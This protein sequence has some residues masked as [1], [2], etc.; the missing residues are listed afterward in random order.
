MASMNLR[1]YINGWNPKFEENTRLLGS[2]SGVYRM[3]H[4]EASGYYSK[5][6]TIISIITII[7]VTGTGTGSFSL[8]NVEETAQVKIL[9]GFVLYVTALLSGIKDFLNLTQISEKHKLYSIRFSALY[10]NIQRQLSLYPEERQNGKDYIS[11]VNSE[12]DNLLFSNPDI[13]SKIKNKL[14]DEFG[15]VINRDIYRDLTSNETHIVIDSDDTK[16][17]VPMITITTPNDTEPSELSGTKTLESNAIPIK[18][19]NERSKY[20]I[21]RYMNSR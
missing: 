18:R 15:D 20:E 19:I 16:D 8:V 1:G 4:D 2:K 9:I 6:N 21:E 17:K 10:N 11:W 13:P 12:F 14:L 5:I 7:L 3:M